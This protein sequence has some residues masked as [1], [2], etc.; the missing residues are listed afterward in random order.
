MSETSNSK[1][2]P[3]WLK[4]ALTLLAV[5]V[6]AYLLI[7]QWTL[8]RVY[9]G[10]GEMLI[11]K[12]NVGKANPNPEHYQVVDKGYKGILK[13]VVGE[14][15]HFY[16]PFLYERKK[17]SDTITIR[18]NEVGIVVSKSGDPLK[19]GRFLAE[20]GQKG[21]LRAP[22]TPGKWR[23]NPIAFK[24]QKMKA[25]RIRAGYVG[26]V[27][28]LAPDPALGVLK[29]GILKQVL[30]PGIYYINHKAYKVEEVEIGYHQLTLNDIQFK[31]VDGFRIQLDVSVVWGVNPENVPHLIRTLGNIRQIVSK[32]IQPQVNT[33]VRLEGSKHGAREFIEG[34]TR[35]K[36]QKEFTRQLKK[37]GN[38]KKIEILIGLVRNIEI[39]SE[40]RN[41]INQAKIAVEQSK[42]KK[43]MGT[44]QKLRNQLE[45]LKQDVTKGIREANAKTKQMVAKIQADGQKQI[46]SIQG[47]RKVEVAK[48]MRKVAEIQA[49]IKLLKGTAEATVVSMNKR[50]KAD[51][52]VQFAKALGSAKALA[53]YSFTRN[54][55]KDLQ[56]MM[57]YAGPGTFW[58]DM[59]R[60]GN[61]LNRAANAKILQ[62]K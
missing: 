19:A 38:D 47:Q 6:V 11:I 61:I 39:P 53:Q 30:Q 34:R 52:F 1:K 5:F 9:V 51:R 8:S 2:K 54:L 24:V 46:L 18:P 17:I 49:K 23:L 50:A 44:T 22:L 45:T 21:I 16:N 55:R 35:L 36:F 26:C 57:R 31:S 14:G 3:K 43:E 59:P 60:N 13:N 56:I 7:W 37:I 42:T 10:P 32:I 15:R 28:A 33:I 4:M 25:V 48:I 58:T 12:S 29:Q 62:R 41:P 40:I 27:T 20:T